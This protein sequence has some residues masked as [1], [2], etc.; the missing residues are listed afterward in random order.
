MSLDNPCTATD[1]DAGACVAID[2]GICGAK[3]TPL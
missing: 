1:F 2:R 3:K